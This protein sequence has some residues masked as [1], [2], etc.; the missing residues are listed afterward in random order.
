MTMGV[1]AVLEHATTTRQM[2]SAMNT[3]R[4]APD[5]WPCISPLHLHVVGRQRSGLKPI[6]HETKGEATTFR[7]LGEIRPT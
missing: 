7:S 3:A 6:C 4:V 2:A 1:A 5:M